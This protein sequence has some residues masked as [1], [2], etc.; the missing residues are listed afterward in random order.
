MSIK[1]ID[2]LHRVSHVEKTECVYLTEWEDMFAD[3]IQYI[4]SHSFANLS[5]QKLIVDTALLSIY[6]IVLP[7]VQ[8]SILNTLFFFITYICIP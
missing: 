4:F 7:F 1:L 3:N 6:C 2:Y 5:S 8:N